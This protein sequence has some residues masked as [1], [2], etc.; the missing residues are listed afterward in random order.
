MQKRYDTEGDER[1]TDEF[2]KPIIA[3]E[4]GRIKG[5]VKNYQEWNKY[6]NNKII[7]SLHSLT[8]LLPHCKP[9]LLEWI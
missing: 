2:L 8:P 5:R 4:E 1:Q 9:Y 6:K 3:S 7:F